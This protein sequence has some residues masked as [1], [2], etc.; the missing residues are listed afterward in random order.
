MNEAQQQLIV[1]LSIDGDD[2]IVNIY[3]KKGDD[4]KKITLPG[5]AQ[6]LT[7]GI[8]KYPSSGVGAPLRTAA[9]AAR[10]LDRHDMKKD[11]FA[12]P[13]VDPDVQKLII[14]TI[15]GNEPNCEGNDFWSDGNKFPHNAPFSTESNSSISSKCVLRLMLVR[16]EDGLRKRLPNA[17]GL[18][19]FVVTTESGLGGRARDPASPGYVPWIMIVLFKLGHAAHR[20]DEGPGGGDFDSECQG[21]I[22][23]IHEDEFIKQG[24]YRLDGNGDKVSLVSKWEATNTSQ[25]YKFDVAYRLPAPTGVLQ[26]VDL[27][28]KP[29]DGGGT[30]WMPRSK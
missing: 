16:D 20:A 12:D 14:N 24:F 1:E 11:F 5:G 25:G 3:E 6:R 21:V 10:D 2:Y 13:R 23:R 19:E 28:A 4:E 22:M 29:E 9:A 7:D 8:L 18:S 26:Q 27:L 17:P 15:F 30:S